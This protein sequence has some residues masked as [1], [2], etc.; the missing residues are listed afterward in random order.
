MKLFKSDRT[1]LFH[2]EPGYVGAFTREQVPGALLNGTTVEKIATEKG[3][4]H[5]IGEQ[6]VVL[7]SINNPA[8]PALGI[9]YFVE[10]NNL[11][12]HAV[13]CIHWKL[14]KVARR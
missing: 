3:D 2:E 11:P 7:G 10:W 14:N 9:M 4:T 6:A 8:K 1:D 5:A 12:G 13:A